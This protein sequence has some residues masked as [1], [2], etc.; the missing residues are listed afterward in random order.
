MTYADI[1]KS[2]QEHV[3][4]LI[5]QGSLLEEENESA[6]LYVSQI[7]SIFHHTQSE[8]AEL[9]EKNRDSILFFSIANAYAYG[10]AVGYNLNK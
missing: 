3:R 5:E 6:D 7:Q 9:N 8:L 2:Q 4:N 1:L 10:L